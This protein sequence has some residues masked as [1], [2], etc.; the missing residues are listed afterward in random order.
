MPAC[1]LF[2]VAAI[3]VTAILMKTK[4]PFVKLALV[5]FV[6][7]M[8]H[9]A[10][11]QITYCIPPSTCTATLKGHITLVKFNSLNSTSAC[12][13]YRL[14]PESGATTTTLER[15][16]TYR[17]ETG[18]YGFNRDLW[19]GGYEFSEQ[20]SM[21]YID[22]NGDGDFEDANEHIVAGRGNDSRNAIGN[23]TIPANAKIGKTRLRVRQVIW[24]P[25]AIDMKACNDMIYGSGYETEDYTITIAEKNPSVPSC[26]TVFYPANNAVNVPRN[27]GTVFTWAGASGGS[28]TTYDFYFGGSPSSLAAMAVNLA[29]PDGYAGSYN[30]P[31]FLNT[32]TDYYYKIVPKNNKGFNAACSVQKFTTA[33]ATNDYYCT[34]IGN[35]S[36][37]TEYQYIRSVKINTLTNVS[38]C[39]GNK[40]SYIHFP[41]S[42]ATTTALAKGGT[43][44]LQTEMNMLCNSAYLGAW[45][46]FNQNGS[47]EDV[48]EF[49]AI[50]SDCNSYPYTAPVVVPDQAVTGRT[51]MRVRLSS[52]TPI[53]ASSSCRDYTSGETE[54]YTITIVPRGGCEALAATYTKTDNLLSAGEA[55]GSITITPSG[56]TPAYSIG[57]AGGTATGFVPTGLQAGVYFATVTDAAGCTHATPPININAPPVFKI[58]NINVVQAGC[59]EGGNIR[60]DVS[61]GT[62]PYTFDWGSAPLSGGFNAHLPEGAYR[63]TVR[64]S[65]GQALPSGPIQI[66]SFR[67]SHTKKDAD[68]AFG[69]TGEIRLAVKGGI[70]TPPFQTYQYLW[71]RE[72][73]NETLYGWN[74]LLP[75]RPPGI[76]S[77]TVTDASGCTLSIPQ[78]TVGGPEAVEVRALVTPINCNGNGAT[79]GEI[80][81]SAS[82]GQGPY[83]YELYSGARD[84]NNPPLPADFVQDAAGARFVNVPVSV[85]SYSVYAYDANNCSSDY[86][87]VEINELAELGYDG[88]TSICSGQP[89][90]LEYYG[91]VPGMDFIWYADAAGTTPLD[92]AVVFTTPVLAQST[93]YYYANYQHGCRTG[94]FRYWVDVARPIAKPVIAAPDGTTLCG[95]SGVPLDAPAGFP[96]YT[97]SNGATTR[98]INVQGAGTF[99]VQVKDYGCESPPSDPVTVMVGAATLRPAITANAPTTFCAGGSVELSVPAGFAQY[100]WSTGATSQKITATEG[101][102]YTVK[103]KQGG[104]CES[105]LSDPVAVKVN[106]LPAQPRITA[107]GPVAFCAGGTVVLSAPDGFNGYAWS[108]GATTKNI[109]VGE[110]GNYS[111]KVKTAAAC[112]SIL[113]EAA[114]VTVSPLPAQPR[115]TASGSVAFCAGGTVVLSA[116]DGLNGYAWST[117]ATTQ[118]VTV[119]QGGDYSVKVRTAAGCESILSEAATVTVNPLPASPR[120]TASGPVSFCAGGMVALSAP[121]GY[122]GYTWSTGATTKTVT[123]G[124][125]GDYSVK[126]RTAALCESIPS[127]AATVTV[128]PLPARPRITASG[129]VSFCAGGTVALSAPDGYVGYAWSTG[130][131]TKNITVGESGNYSVA[132]SNGCEGPPSGAAVVTVLALPATP[133]GIVL[134]PPDILKASGKGEKYEW[135]LDNTVLVANTSEIKASVSGTYRVRGLSREGCFSPGSVSYSFVVTGLENS[136]MQGFAVY[137]NPSGGVFNIKAGSGMAGPAEVSVVNAVGQVVFVRQMDFRSE[138]QE[139]DLQNPSP[140]LYH[141]S[142]R[143]GEKVFA[144]KI[145]VE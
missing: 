85:F 13:G 115:I 94:I 110:N 23:I 133:T 105:A 101:G 26:P 6:S 81:V 18:F 130:A 135:Q 98:S 21:V 88:Y 121:D 108:T 142:I 71:R 96:V 25:F 28:N 8:V 34:P 24:G 30:Y 107:S 58:E 126:V 143:K 80:W 103:V 41:A 42:G 113:S 74:D 109:T 138:A 65:K 7:A 83:R 145:V 40:I 120:I 51:R 53:L 20:F 114:I 99:S 127:E 38:S 5:F 97:W 52:E 82:K 72:D 117:G 64:D 141:L 37:S 63:V 87:R 3:N 91:Y 128:N 31:S 69:N 22:F 36:L 123:V 90:K 2:Q 50:P 89:A 136:P 48:G 144:G 59:Q 139:I 140:G 100:S 46:D 49:F 67:V 122:S 1:L 112:E 78:I 35:C 60:V 61:G 137:P 92:T 54:D 93:D 68:C 32:G 132:V 95:D 56:G 27:P 118:T 14:F 17:M 86:A 104:V 111:V 19:H 76:Y 79:T 45:I 129:P 73:T 12:D 29:S 57:W 4:M 16:A 55:N 131:T 125:G 9:S 106:P 11:A 33:S 44:T 10:S 70:P 124:Q 134:V 66:D 102:D 77:V 119:G 39:P 43:Y 62:G 84:A 75:G 47:F 116:P 15:S